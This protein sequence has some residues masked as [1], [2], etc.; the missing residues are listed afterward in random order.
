[1]GTVLAGFGVVRVGFTDGGEDTGREEVAA[2]A[3]I[4]NAGLDSFF[5]RQSGGSPRE[6]LL[7]FPE[8]ELA[9]VRIDQCDAQPLVVDKFF[10]VR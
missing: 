7:C 1:M 10:D 5:E 9:G 2:F 8:E 6:G 4:P 3:T